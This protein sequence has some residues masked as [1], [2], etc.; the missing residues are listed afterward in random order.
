MLNGVVL[1]KWSFKEQVDADQ[2][3]IVKSLKHLAEGVSHER[4]LNPS[5]LNGKEIEIHDCETGKNIKVILHVAKC[6]ED[7]IGRVPKNILFTL[8]HKTMVICV[9]VN[10]GI[11]KLDLQ[12]VLP[13]HL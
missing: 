6:R 9:T 1:G 4:G 11:V 10:Q 2:G 7:Q 5:Y 3:M 12:Y 13:R 8:D